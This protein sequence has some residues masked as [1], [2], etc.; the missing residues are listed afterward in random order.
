MSIS[1]DSLGLPVCCWYPKQ[2]PG[3]Y[4]DLGGSLSGD[5]SILGGLLGRGVK[6]PKI[7]TTS[8]CHHLSSVPFGQFCLRIPSLASGWYKALPYWGCP[9][10]QKC[11]ARQVSQ[12]RRSTWRL[13]LYCEALLSLLILSGLL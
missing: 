11:K 5:S 13:M 4:A 3:L 10:Q 8:R 12:E 6:G 2:M 1:P 9:L 7:A